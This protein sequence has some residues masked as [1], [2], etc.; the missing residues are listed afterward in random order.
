VRAA[1]RRARAWGAAPAGAARARRLI[2]ALKEARAA[3]ALRTGAGGFPGEAE[4]ARRSR[5]AAAA[6]AVD[7]KRRCESCFTCCTAVGG[8]RQRDCLTQRMRAAAL[9]GHA[10]A[11]VAICGV[12]A[13]GARLSIWW[14]G[15][16]ASYDCVVAEYDAFSTECVRRG[17]ARAP[18][19]PAPLRFVPRAHARLPPAP[20]SP[21]PRHIVAYDDGEVGV[22]K[23]WQHDERIRL[24]TE[25]REW[26]AAARAYAERRRLALEVNADQ[27]EGG[28]G[29]AAAA[30]AAAAEAEVESAEASAPALTRYELDRAARMKRNRAMLEALFRG[31]E[32]VRGGELRADA[33]EPGAEESEE[34]DGEDADAAGGSGSG[35]GKRP[36]T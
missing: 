22:H 8:A 23:L 10:G 15:D 2:D 26:P 25:P 5:A 14:E 4:Q 6:A 1:T 35:G 29:A 20:P 33:A 17:R 13:I 7:L 12:G 24:L 32:G 9:A 16:Q 18:F 28:R 34:G 21:P 30:A 3:H 19:V 31:A 11:Q 27:R 36:R